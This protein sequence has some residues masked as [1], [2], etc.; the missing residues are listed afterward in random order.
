MAPTD[1]QPDITNVDVIHIPFE[2]LKEAWRGAVF[3]SDDGDLPTLRV[4]P[5]F[6]SVETAVVRT[7]GR[8][9]GHG[10]GI[11]IR[12]TELPRTGIWNVDP[13]D[14]VELRSEYPDDEPAFWSE[15]WEIIRGTIS[16]EICVIQQGQ[17]DGLEPITNAT[18]YRVDVRIT[19]E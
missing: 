16:D 11:D 19:D 14:V 17:G 5:P 1:T 4:S 15:Y 8:K 10:D 7:D 13:Y 2:A 18:T 9:P 12:P 6:N 3:N